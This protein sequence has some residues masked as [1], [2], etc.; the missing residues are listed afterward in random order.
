VVIELQEV[1][2]FAIASKLG[3]KIGL[4]IG[5]TGHPR[6]R[7]SSSIQDDMK[8]SKQPVLPSA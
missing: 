4:S 1:V 2:A 7:T 8:P 6:R 3:Y 5:D